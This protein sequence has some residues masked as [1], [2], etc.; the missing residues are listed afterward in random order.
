[1]KYLDSGSIRTACWTMLLLL[2]TEWLAADTFRFLG[3]NDQNWG[4]GLSWEFSA[5]PPAD[6]GNGQ[7]DVFVRGAGGT[8]RLND[9]FDDPIDWNIR[10]LTFESQATGAWGH[11]G[12]TLF[13]GSI[14]NNDANTH[15]FSNA[16]VRLKGFTTSVTAAS[17]D[18]DFNAQVALDFS[19]SLTGV[20]LNVSGGQSVFFDG[21]VTG[22]FAST[23]SNSTL[24]ISGGTFVRLG[25]ASNIFDTI[26]ITSGT[27]QLNANSVLH[28]DVEVTVSTGNTFDL[29]G[30]NS[31]IGQITGG[32][33][34]TLGAGTLTFGL[35]TDFTFSGAISGTGGITKNGNG[36]TTLTGVSNY[37][38]AT[39]ITDGTLRLGTGGSLSGASDVSV[40]SGATFDLN[41]ISDT[42]DSVSGAGT[43]QL[44]GGTLTVNETSGS[45]TFS[46][47][48]QETGTFSKQGAGTLTL[49]GTNTFT[50]LDV[51]AGILQVSSQGN[52]GSGTVELSGGEL[53]ATASFTNAR[54]VN[55]NG[56][57]AIG[58]DTGGTFT[59]SGVVSGTGT[60]TKLGSGT[61][62]L[63][64][65][66]TYTG[67]TVINGGLLQLSAANRIADA[68]DVVLGPGAT[69]DMNNFSETI[70]SI[71]GTGGTIDTGGSS[72]NLT[73]NTAAGTFTYAGS[74]T[75]A[76]NFNKNGAHTLILSGASSI[77]GNVNVN[78]GVLQYA[79]GGS[80]PA[81][82]DVIVA[83]GATWNLNGIS[84]FV[85]S[86]SGEGAIQLGSASLTVN[87]ASGSLTLS[88]NISG[89]G[90]S[91]VKSG[92][93][94]LIL[95]GTNSYTGTTTLDDGILQ[96]GTSANLG[97]GGLIFDSGIIASTGNISSSRP[98][99]INQFD[100]ATF[101]VASGTTFTHS[102]SIGGDPTTQFIKSGAGTFRWVGANTYTGVV[103][104]NG[105]ILDV[106]VNA[107]QSIALT[108]TIVGSGSFNKSD[109]GMLTLTSPGT[110]GGSTSI[111]G[112]TLILAG[113][114]NLPNTTDIS[115]SS[116]ATFDL[117]GVNDTVDS[118]AGAGSVLLGGAE[119][120][121]GEVSGT[122]TLSGAISE[123]GSLRKGGA[124]TWILSGANTFTGPI[125][126]DG[127]ILSVNSNGNLGNV[128][129]AISLGAATLQATGS[130][131][132]A[133][134]I[135]LHGPGTIDVL[136]GAVLTEQGLV[137]GNF[138]LTKTGPG[139]LILS[140]AN[141]YTGGTLIN[142]GEVAVSTSSGLG[143]AASSVSLSG[144]NL[145]AAAS[146]TNSRNVQIAG[147]G[148]IKV[149][150]GFTL[151]QSGAITGTGSLTKLGA[152]TLLLTTPATH[153]GD[154]TI[155][156]GTLRF[157]SGGLPNLFDVTVT[158]PGVWDLNAVSD[159]V[160][161]LFG[162]GSVQ[163][164]SG[165][166]TLGSAGGNGNFTGPITGPGGIV[167][168]GAG[169]QRFSGTNTH[170]SMQL[171][172][173]IVE[174]SQDSSLG[175]PGIGLVF[176][177]GALNSTAT[178]SI[179]RNVT[180][181]AAGGTFDVNGAT[182]L[183]VVNPVSGV[184]GLTKTGAGTLVLQAASSFAGP[185]SILNGT[186][187]LGTGMTFGSLSGTGT[188]DLG[189]N[190]LI[191]NGTGDN[192]F[193]G[194]LSGI[195]GKLT[196]DGPGTLTLT[197][198]NTYTGGTCILDGVLRISQTANLG[199]EGT[200]ITFDGGTLNTMATFSMIRGM[201][202]NAGGGTI[203]TNSATSLN[204]SG[205]ITGIGTLTKSGVGELILSGF[206]SYEGG[207]RILGGEL[208][209]SSNFNLGNSTGTL[210]FD[211]GSLHSTNNI[212]MARATTL[213]VGGGTFRTDAGTTLTQTNIISGNAN[214]AGLTKAGLGNLRLQ[215][216]N[217]FVGNVV[218]Q[219]GKLQVDSSGQLG[220]SSN[221]LRMQG[222]TLNTLATL[223]NA[224]I[225]QLEAGVTPSTI[226]VATGT[227]F[228]QA[229]VIANGS[230]TP[231][232]TLRKSGE[233]TLLLSAANVYTSPTQIDQG[234]LRL[235]GDGRLPD[236]TDLTV[237][238]GTT[239]DLNN[240]SDAIDGL[241]GEGDV[242]LGSG[243][244]TVGAGNGGGTFGGLISG[245][246]SFVKTGTGRQ[247]ISS[248][249]NMGSPVPN[250]YAGGTT[251]SG[252]V[253]NIEQDGN[254]G[255]PT[256][257][258]TFNA[259]ELEVEQRGQGGTWTTTRSITLQ[260]GGGTIDLLTRNVTATTSGVITGA[261]SLTKNGIGRLDLNAA[262]TYTGATIINEGLVR[263]VGAGRLPDASRVEVNVISSQTDQ[264]GLDLNDISDAING[265]D[266][267][268]EVKLG[269]ATLS[270]GA[271]NGS[272]NFSGV[273]LG[274]G[275]VTK[276]GTGTQIFSG[277][278]TYAAGTQI[279][280]GVLQVSANNHL[281][282]ASGPLTITEGTLRTTAS[283][284]T[285]RNT[286]L[287]AAGGTLDVATGTT[288]THSAA[289][290]GTGG[291]TKLG[292]GT[293][294]TNGIN[295]YTGA[296][297][298]HA[299]TLRL[300][301]VE[302]LS[303][304]TDVTVASGAT[305]DLNN[306]NESI[307]ALAGSGTVALQSA[308]LVVGLN[309][310]SGDFNGTIIGTGDL[311][312]EGTGIQ[313]L[314]GQNTYS[315]ATFVDRG[316]LILS[317]GGDIVQST[318]VVGFNIGSNGILSIDG[319]GTTWDL[320]GNFIV[321]L[322]GTARANIRNGAVVT[323]DG[324]VII[325]S[326]NQGAASSGTLS[327]SNGTLDNSLGS[328]IDVIH[329]TLQGHGLI[330]GNV[331]N[332]DRVAPG[333]S[334]GILTVNGNLVQ[335]AG[336]TLGFEI[337]GRNNSNLASPQFDLL[338]VS[339]NLALD[340]LLEVSLLNGFQPVPAD[341][342]TIADS[343]TLVGSFA[344]VLSGGRV[345]LT[346][347]GV[348]SFR[349]H[350]GTGSPFGSDKLVLTDFQGTASSSGDFNNDG[351]FNCTDI[352]SLVGQMV[353]G[354]NNP[355]F[356][357]TGDG[358]V[359]QADLVQWRTIAG[360]I[361]LASGNPYL[362]G[363]GNLD[364]VVDGSDFGIWN[365]NKFTTIAAWCSGDY[366]ADGIV[367]GSD[368]G[369]WNGNKFTSSDGGLAAVPEP[370][371]LLCIVGWA[372][373]LIWRLRFRV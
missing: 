49:S 95:S 373:V 355:Q 80:L 223:T 56:S 44:G 354:S 324:D 51:G 218:L 338:D 74:M 54:A 251:I 234:I 236:V 7:S 269:S 35:D 82:A 194:I 244:L 245:T 213:G 359:N 187:Q 260:S 278:S 270:I 29:N 301:G 197:G 322:D 238:T 168:I 87:D 216:S 348:G 138:A 20:T 229:G 182:T 292:S 256:G 237:G 145:R 356:D 61:L 131:T 147:S 312:K 192:T 105:G 296:T 152:G 370:S 75:G 127:G 155:A 73:V 28:T 363:D 352:N 113:G 203:D 284:S 8:A 206:S 274:A 98:I 126:I 132:S 331:T 266:G 137:S 277:N 224:R 50:L 83:N 327:L 14:T 91:F 235:A 166:L 38:G 309:N 177:G 167:K 315:G 287:G 135:S 104:I 342:F 144:G 243:T 303:N 226:E 160:D 336:A 304:Q 242:T 193:G 130:F 204:A 311:L 261:G 134:N 76:G 5:A 200:L 165:A 201:A 258:L 253:L 328:G 209:I 141:T 2:P 275:G 350:Y 39:N 339:G 25:G 250:T 299:G 231:P 128:A 297:S 283:F 175:A 1:M 340:G 84:D 72:G 88:G 133:H 117:N 249:V 257:P 368:F 21:G 330:R 3:Q 189:G 279:L 24:N 267:N 23:S 174:V 220:D 364:G 310:G 252:G 18:L 263:L 371:G 110:Y 357:M 259:G 362:P 169:R 233:G 139:S 264:Q 372:I 181:N 32:G 247:L 96:I 366:S 42:V 58:V 111:T 157:G 43:I 123:T 17:G 320:S 33:N 171:N 151:T 254:L 112:G 351:L 239:F 162:N 109:P 102:A 26:N 195:G 186:L 143:N 360:S 142:G 107:A 106:G 153:A 289:I 262:N 300:G 280:G 93:H 341:V 246:G 349:V 227:V 343:A 149:D 219:E 46:G 365:G 282:S 99:T 158:S 101:D 92:A 122:R 9:F 156:A 222:G 89:A 228:T 34:V 210:F 66:N 333:N 358:L 47:A 185:M 347:G 314:T 191:L 286:T 317:D 346:S 329:G 108:A 316:E 120:A 125:T 318:T 291:L 31:N 4:N 293:L 37:S 146:F 179:P 367:D 184:G 306:F 294:L 164:N 36:I 178:F 334:A 119:L 321:G 40:S 369:I 41:G 190:E 100:T 154:T 337:G 298:I 188:I 290:A 45:R 103:Q 345:N 212:L 215:G 268:G 288:I 52:L 180:L 176:S 199:E 319:V 97:S 6:G 30:F 281:G 12:G 344:N 214:A 53:R 57:G 114:G 10:S 308:A 68:S 79:S 202:L 276:L 77:S 241:A 173:G 326:N 272:G 335:N 63:S 196:K 15:S 161:G 136:A 232:Q 118:I 170:T 205:N 78:A 255:L 302:R 71:S 323:S 60:L 19:S 65:V 172:G 221:R 183:T 70:A 48:I 140:A 163:L 230:L 285:A 69:W 307:D 27:L 313:R 198:I 332:F 150:P 94:T 295:T 86:I 115:I 361:N 81:A 325:G 129:N 207:T 16:Q 148:G 124:H 90:G 85:E 353:L 13:V 208:S 64:A 11:I 305:F 248:R 22:E 225:M 271:T 121:V 59:Q 55:A 67:D 273:I 240:I 211:G 159:T 217:S 265:L 116:G 62:V